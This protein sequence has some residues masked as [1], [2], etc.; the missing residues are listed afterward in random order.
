MSERAC[1]QCQGPIPENLSKAAKYCSKECRTEKQNQVRKEKLDKRRKRRENRASMKPILAVE[2]REDGT[3]VKPPKEPHLQVSDLPPEQEPTPSN[4][5]PIEEQA[6]SYKAMIEQWVPNQTMLEV[7]RWSAPRQAFDNWM[8]D[9]TDENWRP[10]EPKAIIRQ[11][12]S[13]DRL[14]QGIN[15]AYPTGGW[16]QIRFYRDGTTG[17]E[18]LGYPMYFEIE[19]VLDTEELSQMIGIYE[20]K[21]DEYKGEKQSLLEKLEEADSKEK[22]LTTQ[23]FQ[24]VREDRDVAKEEAKALRDVNE[25]WQQQMIENMT[26][27]HQKDLERMEQE[28]EENQERWEQFHASNQ[29]NLSYLA[30]LQNNNRNDG[31]INQLV[32]AMMQ[33]SNE[34]AQ[35]QSMQMM[36]MVQ[37]MMSQPKNNGIEAMMPLILAL[38]SKNDNGLSIKEIL[39]LILQNQQP[40]QN[41]F[42]QF[43][44]FAAVQAMLKS[45]PDAFTKALHDRFQQKMLEQLDGTPSVDDP[46]PDMLDRGIEALEKIGVSSWIKSKVDNASTPS[47]PKSESKDWTAGLRQPSVN[48]PSDA[49]VAVD[50]PSN[51]VAPA[52][53]IGFGQR[54]ELP[55]GASNAFSPPQAQQPQ[56][57]QPQ[58]PN[59]A[60]FEP[61]P[62]EILGD[63]FKKLLG[64]LK[65]AFDGDIEP[66]KIA[67]TLPPS[68]SDYKASFDATS[69]VKTIQHH[70]DETLKSPRCEKW[71]L[72]V[73]EAIE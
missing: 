58:A 53:Q 15:K 48:A 27:N 50:I 6:R 43:Q 63:D 8:G 65:D 39:P 7:R 25:R 73:V 24:M 16:F 30:S 35:R 61:P 59:T 19:P 5:F 26:A 47:R 44:Q 52:A 55:P 57:Q 37:A 69:I 32:I 1:E 38:I 2:V 12:Q 22:D 29:Q 51:A 42:E 3:E 21:I 40:Q 60:P 45:E 34:Q 66:Q 28:K 68:A 67:A 4:P 13:W 36:Q 18:S 70:G 9:P 10:I 46:K 41:P 14:R 54:F 62:L 11:K 23:L 72:E 20:S 49:A 56:A 17:P 31:G 64:D 71:L 33:Q